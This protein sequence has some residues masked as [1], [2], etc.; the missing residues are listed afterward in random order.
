MLFRSNDKVLTTG[1]YK[2]GQAK[3][4][5]FSERAIGYIAQAPPGIGGCKELWLQ[6]RRVRKQF[7][8]I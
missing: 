4:L 5:G 7:D 2:L 6:M 3:L 1:T 8:E